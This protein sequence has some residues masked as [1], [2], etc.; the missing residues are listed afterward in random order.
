MWADCANVLLG[1]LLLVFG[2]DSLANGVSGTLARRGAHTHAVALAAAIVA[3]LA[4]AAAIVL[5]A[6]LAAQ[7]ELALGGLIGNAIAQIGV[8]I[9]LSA[10][11]A[12]LLA[13]LRLFAWLNP[14]LPLA[15]LL[16]WALGL[17][18]VY[19]Q[20]DGGILLAAFVLAGFL[21]LRQRAH[22]SGPGA[23]ALGAPPVVS[24]A[25]ILALR[26]LIGLALIGFGGWRLAMAGSGLA[27]ALALNPLIPGLLVLG[28]ACA[29]AGLPTAVL[30]ARRGRSD[31]ALGQGLIAALG[32]ILLLPGALALWQPM[33]AA[34][35]LSRIE[36]PVLAAL[37]I[38]LYPM[39]RSDG[40]LSRR[41]GVV[42]LV[43]YVIWM[44]GE[45]WLTAY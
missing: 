21:L 12:P 29:L 27:A 16:I 9:G 3:G 45:C 15:V 40:A 8:L 19:S 6:L 24:G 7:N 43:T 39:M 23:S 14:M 22:D 30:A 4:P 18:H 17:D 42:L 31:F 5:A 26:I 41:E 28:P 35:S 20:V 2:T 33:A 44:L 36:L 37:A 38:A 1:T 25:P 10:L 34:E 13:R 32:S 11:L